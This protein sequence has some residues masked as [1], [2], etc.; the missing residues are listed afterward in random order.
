MSFPHNY[1]ELKVQPKSWSFVGIAIYVYNGNPKGHIIKGYQ[2]YSDEWIK[3]HEG[4]L[5]GKLHEAVYGWDFWWHV[6]K[7]KVSSLMTI[8]SFLMCF[9]N[10]MLDHDQGWDKISN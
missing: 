3:T 6:H 4:F 8:I 5:E 1:K 9:I 7:R 10:L 2:R